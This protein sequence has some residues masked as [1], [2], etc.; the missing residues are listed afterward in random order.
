[1]YR[2]YMQ[3]GATA[4][5][6]DRLSYWTWGKCVSMSTARKGIDSNYT[7]IFVIRF[8]LA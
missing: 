3:N 2:I 4:V 8:A 1:M 7:L 5:H 6:G